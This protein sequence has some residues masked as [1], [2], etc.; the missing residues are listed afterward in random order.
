MGNT[1]S[2]ATP[3]TPINVLGLT[4]TQTTKLKV[5]KKNQTKEFQVLFENS[6]FVIAT[7]A[8][9]KKRKKIMY[10]SSGL[11]VCN[12]KHKPNSSNYSL[13][14]GDESKDEVAWLLVSSNGGEFTFKARLL[15]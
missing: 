12:L 14:I 2:L 4:S 8:F 7:Q 6:T 5:F 3:A 13:F 1:A 9:S 11:A 10:D 15:Y